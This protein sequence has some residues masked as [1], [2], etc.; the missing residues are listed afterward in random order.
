MAENTAVRK[1]RHRGRLEQV[2]IY[3]TKLLRLFVYQNDWKLLPMSVIIAGLVSLVVKK[4]FFVTMEGTLKGAL[5]LSCVAI[6]NGFFNS[7][8]VVC[9][10]REIIKREHRGGMHISSYIVAHMMYQALICLLQ[11]V[12]TVYTCKLMGIQ[13]PA[14]GL[15]TPWMIVDVGI[16][17]F[18][19]SSNTKNFL[20][21]FHSLL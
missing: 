2:G 7:I 12:L 3:F 11:T 21:V 16:T 19:I 17:V 13:F 4:D 10:E 8:Q 1:I 14:E 20:L 6:W 18:L 15:F 5:A 9:R